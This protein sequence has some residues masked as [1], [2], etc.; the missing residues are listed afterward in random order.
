MT[1]EG[2]SRVDPRDEYG[3]A[4][5]RTMGM[6]V[7]ML[8]HLSGGTDDS[9]EDTRITPLPISSSLGLTTA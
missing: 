9:T 2:Q 3:G 5:E 8:M 1:G 7:N 6:G 4:G